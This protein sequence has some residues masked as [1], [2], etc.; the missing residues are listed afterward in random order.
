MSAPLDAFPEELLQA[1]A[2][3][4]DVRSLALF[5][6]CCHATRRAARAALALRTELD[7]REAAL[8][9]PG[10]IALFAM[11][12]RCRRLRLYAWLLPPSAFGLLPAGAEDVDVEDLQPRRAAASLRALS[13]RCPRLRRLRVTCSDLEWWGIDGEL[14]EGDSCEKRRRSNSGRRCGG[15]FSPRGRSPMGPAPLAAPADSAFAFSSGLQ[16][17]FDACRDLESLSVPDFGGRG[18]A[19]PVGTADL[20]RLA[21]VS[22]GYLDPRTLGR[23]SPLRAGAAPITALAIS[24]YTADE[25]ISCTSDAFVLPLVRE[26]PQLT[27][28]SLRGFGGPINGSLSDEAFI[29]LARL[30]GLE[31]LKF[32]MTDSSVFANVTDVGILHLAAS[33]RSLRVLHL[34]GFRRLTDS[35]VTAL[36]RS[37]GERLEKVKLEWLTRLSDVGVE[38][39]AAACPRLRALS[40]RDARR[41]SDAGVAELLAARGASLERL[42]LSN[43]ALGPAAMAAL[44]AHCGAPGAR[45]RLKELNLNG[46][47]VAATDEALSLLAPALPGLRRLTLKSCRTITDAGLAALAAHCRELRDLD[48]SYCPELRDG[49]LA[50]LAAASPRLRRLRIDGCARLSDRALAALASSP[51]GPPRPARPRLPSA[52]SRG[53]HRAGAGRQ[54][55]RL[56]SS[57][58]KGGAADAGRGGNPRLLRGP[59]GASPAPPPALRAPNGSQRAALSVRL[60]ERGRGGLRWLARRCPDLALYVD[61]APARLRGDDGD[62]EEGGRSDASPGA[63]A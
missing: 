15:R 13:A 27:S 43:C 8:D 14:D 56:G 48:L 51:A 17:V 61:S 60:G 18:S 36:A 4:L 33:C 40:L 37:C 16:A 42:C 22:A 59:A 23:S 54:A 63:S 50:A 11:A 5:S 2:L 58:R 39:L 19:P 62:S 57:R 30:P 7:L 6:S 47:H 55:S 45:G 12:P 41:V 1:V 49:G 44:A 3:C 35:A 24:Q 32:G 52:H 31:K 28:L 25:G 29:A 34:S 9:G 53:P 10:A 21:E 38:A 46:C 20:P 26:L